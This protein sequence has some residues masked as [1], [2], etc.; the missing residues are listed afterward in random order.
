MLKRGAVAVFTV[1]YRMR[2]LH[3]AC[4]VVTMA[5]LAV[6]RCFVFNLEGL[7]FALIAFAMPAVHIAA[8]TDTKIFW[9]NIRA[10]KQDNQHQD[11][12]DEERSE[13]MISHNHPHCLKI[14]AEGISLPPRRIVELR[15]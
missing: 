5:V 11:Y 12:Y 14:G 3:D 7:P 1:D 15:S 4:V 6:F 9:N 2:R 10:Q 8:F 13:D